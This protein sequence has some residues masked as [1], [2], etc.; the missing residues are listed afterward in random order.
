MAKD[1]QVVHANPVAMLSSPDLRRL[2]RVSLGT[3]QWP[4]QPPRKYLA[5][6][7][8][9]T[10]SDRAVAVKLLSDLRAQ[11]TGGPDRE[12]DRF[13]LIAKMLMTYPTPNAT[14]QTGAARGD[15]YLEALDDI[16]PAVLA[17]AIKRWNRGEAGE[18]DYRWA[19]APAVLRGVCAKVADPLKDA[20][21]D[22]ESLLGAMTIDQ[23]M[24][25]RPIEKP[26]ETGIVLAMRKA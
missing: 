14:A 2:R 12:T 10:D 13:G 11:S 16:S 19:P 3:V 4:G 18:H 6:G 9:L 23:A 1:L 8:T 26:T 24:D 25:P 21:R 17:E 20:I 15:A 7:L 5:G 22:L